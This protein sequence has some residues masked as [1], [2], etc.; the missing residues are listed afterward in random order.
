MIKITFTA[1]DENVI[2]LGSTHVPSYLITLEKNIIK[3]P[4]RF[5]G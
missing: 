3:K 4:V 1:L 5:S 2:L